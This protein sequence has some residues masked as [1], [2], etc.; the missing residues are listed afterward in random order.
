FLIPELRLL[1]TVDLGGGVHFAPEVEPLEE[2]S[3]LVNPDRDR[4]R[5]P[6]PRERAD[7]DSLGLFE[8]LD[9]DA[10]A[11]L[12]VLAG[13]EVVRVLEVNRIDRALRHKGINDERRGGRLLENLQLV[14]LEA[15]I[16]AFGD[17]IHFHRLFA[18]HRAVNG[19]LETHLNPGAALGV[20]QIEGDALRARGAEELDRNGGQAEGDVEVLEGARHSVVVTNNRAR[21]TPPL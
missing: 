18:R 16:L 20:K 19:T 11:A 12:A 3:V 7:G 2:Q 10:I 5:L 14:G 13:A 17:L 1:P 9:E 21:D 8:R 6:A 4:R 15:D